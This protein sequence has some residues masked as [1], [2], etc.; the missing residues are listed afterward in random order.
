MIGTIQENLK[1]DKAQEIEMTRAQR[2]YRNYANGLY[3][4][5]ENKS[6]IR[7]LEK[8]LNQNQKEKISINTQLYVAF[9]STHVKLYEENMHDVEMHVDCQEKTQNIINVTKTQI[10]HLNM[11]IKRTERGIHDLK[12]N[13]TSDLQHNEKLQNAT[14]ILNMLENRVNVAKN[15]ECMIISENNNLRNIIN[16]MLFDRALFNKLWQRMV[17][18][19]AYDKKFFIDMVE[20]A[21][22]AFN[23]GTDLC[24]KLDAIR[25]KGDR[26]KNLHIREILDLL[27]KLDADHKT[28][29]FLSVKGANRKLSDLENREYKRREEFRDYHI[30]TTDLYNKIISK[31]IKFSNS[32]NI[33]TAL[34][35]FNKREDAFF[36]HFNYMNEL[37]YQIELLNESTKQIYGEI[38]I[39]RN[40][41]QRQ[42]M[43]QFNELE[44][45]KLKLFEEKELTL[46]ELTAQ[47]NYDKNVHQ[48]LTK[49][50]EIFKILKCDDQNLF[51]LLGDHSNIT[52]FNVKKFLTILEERLNL[53]L[54]YVYHIERSDPSTEDAAGG[55]IVRDV[56]RIKDDQIRIEDIVVVQ[57]C[58]ECAEGVEVNRYD[59]EIVWP[60]D[61]SEIKDKVRD[62]V[63]APEI[64]YRL[65]N[66]SKCRLPRSRMIVNKRYQ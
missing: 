51:S 12:M 57:Q 14:K 5:K 37:M 22:L 49:F 17:E 43:N 20:R 39:V 64:Q 60:L 18:R 24:N 62:K 16:N 4:L 13:C 8:N 2:E 32:G 48:L 53:I 50:H 63:R 66:I 27:R 38:N 41:N 28:Q 54:S 1:M 10:N 31:I 44:S 23:Q 9:G 42:E 35:Q 58:A 21:I 19:L 56:D 47:D 15:R 36:A 6:K 26:D 55:F 7:Y 59:E 3:S 65:H 34:D 11:Q 45:L 29:V 33:E 61:V 25:E 52:I 46:N 40:Q 30:K